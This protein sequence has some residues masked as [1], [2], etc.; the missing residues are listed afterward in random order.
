MDL[1]VSAAVQLQVL[2]AHQTM[3][4]MVPQDQILVET[5][6]A[7]AL[8]IIQATP[9]RVVLEVSVVAVVAEAV[10]VKMPIIILV[11]AKVVVAVFEL[12][13]G[14]EKKWEDMQ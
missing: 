3:A 10:Q 11:V 13:A 8:E 7:V 12:Q 2:A 1:T 6:V 14:K 9:V 4:L 5:V